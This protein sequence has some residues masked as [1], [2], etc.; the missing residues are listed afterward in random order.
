MADPSLDNLPRLHEREIICREAEQKLRAAVSLVT[1][2][3][4]FSKLTYFEALSV[5]QNV[6]G[7]E[8]QVFL[9]Y[10]IRFERH[11]NT[12]TPGGFAE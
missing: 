1:C 7:G 6:F 12:S 5:M 3:K 9:K 4:E 2:D 10:A 11:G 8:L